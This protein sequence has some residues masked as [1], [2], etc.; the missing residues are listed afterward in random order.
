M[1]G[2]RKWGIRLAVLLFGLLTAGIL[3]LSGMETAQA[4]VEQQPDPL[5]AEAAERTE[6]LLSDAS[7]TQTMRFL[8]CGHSVTRRV[9]AGPQN[10]GLTFSELQ[11]KYAD[12][13]LRD[14]SESAV[15]MEKEL[16][17][18]CPLHYVLTAGDSG[19]IVL[20]NNRYGDG[21]AVEKVYQTALSQMPEETRRQ[22]IYGIG[23]DSREEAEAW[24]GAD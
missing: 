21:M 2:K 17:L 18:F 24:L 11:E 12:W 23:F 14:F 15:S 1:S 7:V 5:N 10:H 9:E 16:A 8:R 20:T 6:R 3:F 22:L 19:E 4:P 13:E